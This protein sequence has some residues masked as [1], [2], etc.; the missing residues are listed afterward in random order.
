M[1]HKDLRMLSRIY[2]HVKK[3][4]DHVKEGLRKATGEVA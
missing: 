1:G 2:Q 3:R 4:S